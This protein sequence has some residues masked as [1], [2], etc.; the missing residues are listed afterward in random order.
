MLSYLAII[1]S[2][3]GQIVFRQ[4]PPDIVYPGSTYTTSWFLSGNQS[5]TETS[6]NLYSQDG[7]Y[8]ELSRGSALDNTF[9][10]TISEIAPEGN[11][12]Y[13]RLESTHRNGSVIAADTPTFT[14]ENN[15]IINLFTFG[16]VLLGVTLACCCGYS[17]YKRHQKETKSNKP[18]EVNGGMYLEQ[19]CA[20]D[21]PTFRQNLLPTTYTRATHPPDFT[22]G[23]AIVT[24]TPIHNLPSD[25]P[26][27]G[28][29]ME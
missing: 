18:R 7:D 11:G 20:T 21:P 23:H 2:S 17:I 24:A 6:V 16:L 14:I 10:W 22:R 29:I 26:V 5:F 19:T 4:F 8:E 12:Y 28:V 3:Y 13:L 15:G 27:I 1:W 25:N 9:I